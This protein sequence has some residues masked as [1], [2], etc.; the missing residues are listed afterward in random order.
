LNTLLKRLSFVLKPVKEAT[1][2][3]DGGIE[4]WVKRLICCYPYFNME[5]GSE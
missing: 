5:M 2:K 4:I 1:L 3:V